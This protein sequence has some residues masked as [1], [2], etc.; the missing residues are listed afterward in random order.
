MLC[1]VFVFLFFKGETGC[2]KSI[3]AKLGVKQPF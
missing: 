1:S 3:R 2:S